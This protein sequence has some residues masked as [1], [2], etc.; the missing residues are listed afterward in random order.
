[1]EL[2]LRPYAA[3]GVAVVGASAI[4]LAPVAPPL[5]DDIRIANPAVSLSATIDPLTPWEQLLED[6]ADNAAGLVDFWAEAPFPVLQQILANQ[7]TYFEELPDFELIAGQIVENFEAA[8]EAPFVRDPYTLS[9]AHQQFYSVLLNGIPFPPYNID[10]I[11][12]A[13]LKPLV[14]FTT[15]YTTGILLG[16]VG[17]VV[18]PVL[19][20]AAN[21]SAIV[22][23]LTSD[24]PDLEAA[25]NTLINTPA[26]MVNAFLNGGETLD[27]TPLIK[28]LPVDAELLDSVG[29]TFGGL[30]SPGGSLFNALDVRGGG[31]LLNVAGQGPGAIGSFIGLTQTIAKALGWDGTGNPLEDDAADNEF[32]PLVEKGSG[33]A[34]DTMLLKAST[35]PV[36]LTTTDDV[37]EEKPAPAAEES[38][39]PTEEQAG[40]AEPVVV[41]DEAA[42]TPA[43]KPATKKVNPG[44]KIAGALKHA[45]D[46]IGKAVDDL[47]K[48]LTKRPTKKAP[49]AEKNDAPSQDKSD[50]PA[51]EKASDDAA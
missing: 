24:E 9:L 38:P 29:I 11:L 10:P 51:K 26:R 28:A 18:A 8:A 2:R 31:G 19:A 7:V 1:M 41:E 23:N 15:S 30:L 16:L 3:A 47:G 4:A 5:P 42:E 13:N 35:T 48:K 39:A 20:L 44:A 34:D 46:Q 49:A 32:I 43:A 12:P 6:A 14:D 45:G 37:A 36:A 33:A 21:V 25:I 27:L 22:E 17:P 50:A 40:D